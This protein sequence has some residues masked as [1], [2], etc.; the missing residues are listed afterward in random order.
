MYFIILLR[1]QNIVI[2]PNNWKKNIVLPFL[3]TVTCP[4][5][6]KKHRV[7]KLRTPKNTTVLS[8]LQYIYIKTIIYIYI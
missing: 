5:K 1:F 6:T 4:R 2:I 3:E 7:S 8:K